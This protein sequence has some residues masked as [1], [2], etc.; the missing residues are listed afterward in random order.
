MYICMCV[1]HLYQDCEYGTVLL[2]A[3]RDTFQFKICHSF[4]NVSCVCCLSGMYCAYLEF[5]LLTF[6]GWMFSL[7]TFGYF[8][9]FSL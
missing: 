4:L 8:C 7:Q 5:G 1:V 3:V 6:I 2:Y 9:L